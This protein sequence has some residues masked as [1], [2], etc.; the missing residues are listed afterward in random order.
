MYNEEYE[1]QDNAKED[2]FI[3][4]FYYNNKILIWIFLGVIAFILLMSL[5]T[6]GGSNGK[7]SVN[8]E[9]KIVY[10]EGTAEVSIGTSNRLIAQV[11]NDAN[12]I[13]VWTSSDEKIVKVDNGTVTGVNYGKAIV[14]ATY[15][16]NDNKRYEA[17]KEVV[18]A[19]GNPN[20]TLTDVSFKDGDLLMPVNGTYNISLRLTPSNGYITNKEFT[21]S[22]TS[23][24]E[25]DNTGLVKA[26]GEGEATISLNVNNGSFRKSLKVYVSRSYDKAEIIVTPERITLDGQLRKIKIGMSEKLS[27]TVFPNDVDKTK[28]IWESSDTSVV[29]VDDNGIIRGLKEGK[30]VVTLKSITGKYDTID[31]EVESDIVEVTSI[32]LSLNY[33]YLN[34]GQSETI[35]PIVSPDNASNKALSYIP[36]DSSIISVI[37]NPT[38]V[39]A[40]IT[41]LRAGTTILTIRS[42]N[43]IEKILNITVTGDNGG[44]SSS[45]GSSGGSTSSKQGFKISSRDA[46]NEGFIYTTYER[47]EPANNG[48]TA[49][50]TVTLEITN[51]SVASLRVAVCSYPADYTC[52]PSSSSSSVHVIYGSGSFAMEQTG[53]YVLRVGE[54]DSNNNLTRTVDKYIWIKEKGSSTCSNATSPTACRMISGCDWDGAYG[55]ISNTTSSS[56]SISCP[57]GTQFASGGSVT[58]TVNLASGDSIKTWYKGSTNMNVKHN[59]IV[60]NGLNPGDYTWTVETTKGAKASVTITITSSSNDGNVKKNSNVK[61]TWYYDGNYSNIKVDYS[62]DVPGT[63]T[64]S[65]LT[66]SCADVATNYKK[67]KLVKGNQTKY[68]VPLVVNQKNCDAEFRL[69]FTPDDTTNYKTATGTFTVHT[70]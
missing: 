59:P 11:T 52:D 7:T 44:G 35:T 36:G 3:K 34:V 15:T 41:A 18:V 60:F 28:L 61:Y 53:A 42:N 58:C 31:I 13:I 48:A 22:N 24:V 8:Y 51:S 49:P 54:Y 21:S 56:V 43:N 26:V 45:G 69:D 67:V 27:Y 5:L 9:V 38:G 16:S 68:G 6:K 57:N 1:E 37:P 63:M 17:T 10:P 55:C 50:V 47:T 4:N 40:Q 39:S 25:V 20:L 65:A 33:L 70:K 46:N 29:T 64:T 23:V 62:A 19:D 2:S 14:T 12:A 30:A 32:D 66:P